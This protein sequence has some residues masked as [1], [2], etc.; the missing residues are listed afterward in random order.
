M[1][2]RIEKLDVS[3]AVLA[4]ASCLFM[5]ID[6]PVWAIFIGW[7]WY[8][9]LSAMPARISRCILP[10]VCG[11]ALA[12]LAYVLIDVFNRIITASHP[13][14]WIIAVIIPVIITVFLL[15]LTLKAPILNVS[16]AS[17]NA[18]SCFFVGFAAETYRSVAGF[19][20]HMNALVWIVG[21]N[22]IGLLFGWA[23]I[24]LSQLGDKD[25]GAEGLEKKAGAGV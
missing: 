15:M 9:T 19:E 7:A 20:V 1:K 17:F 16:L 5:Y 21:A 24:K 14:L 18:Y 12:V 3:V 10:A 4:G 13:D 25:K 6:V 8:F 22:I 2:F 23:S 11:G